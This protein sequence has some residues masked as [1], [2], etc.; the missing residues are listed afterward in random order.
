MTVTSEDGVAAA[1]RR[2]VA[3]LTAAR[4]WEVHPD[5]TGRLVALVAGPR[6]PRRPHRAAELLRHGGFGAFDRTRRRVA[7]GPEPVL[8]LTVHDPAAARDTCGGVRTLTAPDWSPDGRRLAG[9]GPWL[10]PWLADPDTGGC[11]TLAVPVTRSLLGLRDRDFRSTWCDDSGG[12]VTL[13][14]ASRRHLTDRRFDTVDDGAWPSPVVADWYDAARA[15][16]VR[17]VPGGDPEVLAEGVVVV[18]MTPSPDRRHVLLAECA[19][20]GELTELLHGD[21]ARHRVYRLDGDAVPWDL[22]NLRRG[23]LRWAA[24]SLLAFCDVDGDRAEFWAAEPH[25]DPY[26]IGVHRGPVTDWL[27]AAPDLVY[28]LGP[29]RLTAVGKRPATTITPPESPVGLRR[30]G[31]GV[32]VDLVGPADAPG[33]MSVRLDGDRLAVAGRW[34]AGVTPFPHGWELDLRERDARLSRDGVRVRARTVGPRPR[35]ATVE[36][37]EVAGVRYRLFRDPSADVAD[38]PVV[39][40]LTPVAGGPATSEH[41][42]TGAP[43]RREPAPAT[44]QWS[45]L[46]SCAVLTVTCP[47]RWDERTGFEELR[48]RLRDGLTGVLDAVSDRIDPAA[49]ALYGHSF[50]AACAAVLLADTGDLFR[51]A[52]LRNGAYNRTLTPAGFQTERRSLWRAPDVY[53]GFTVVRAADRITAPVLL[54][55]GTADLNGA[56][57]VAQARGFYDALRTAGARARLLLVRDEGHVFATADGIGAAVAEEL[58]WIHRWTGYPATAVRERS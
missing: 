28:V 45:Y 24:P 47:L 18:T 57:T 41:R 19:D 23:S 15:D 13:R 46:P 36:S 44:P 43:E 31:D 11:D 35:V 39:V 48:A 51:C 34:P 33:A 3:D 27:P 55:Q 52:V 6:Y 58:S 14:D 12:L 53:D 1:V 26:R 10:R 8:R 2:L 17:A 5:P 37:G 56:T 25:A 54:V 22:G 32:L 20:P 29:D 21:T 42:P 40:C 16:L 4:R 49:T 50:G 9:V 38:R 30:H 7:G